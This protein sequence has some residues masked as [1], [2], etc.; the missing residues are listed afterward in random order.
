MKTS[1]LDDQIVFKKKRGGLTCL[2]ILKL[3]QFV[4]KWI[5]ASVMSLKCLA[6]RLVTDAKVSALAAVVFLPAPISHH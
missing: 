6:N 2:F 4:I 1:G 5:L 3:V